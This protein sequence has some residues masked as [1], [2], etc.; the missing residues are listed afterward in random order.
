MDWRGLLLLGVFLTLT[1]YSSSQPDEN[2][3][4]FI[5]QMLNEHNKLRSEVKPTAANM[6]YMSWD[7]DLAILAK[8]WSDACIYAFNTDLL[9]PSTEYHPTFTTFEENEWYGPPGD[10]AKAIPEWTVGRKSFD[11][12]ANAC[13]VPQETC[14]TYTGMIWHNTYRV[15]CAATLCNRVKNKSG[16][17]NIMFIC[18]YAPAGNYPNKLPYTE[19][20]PCSKC[21]KDDTCE[22]NLC[23]NPK[24]DVILPDENAQKPETGAA[25]GS[26]AGR[27]EP[28]HVPPS[29]SEA[30]PNE[31]AE[32]RLSS[33]KDSHHLDHLLLCMSLLTCF[34]TLL[35]LL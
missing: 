10:Y 19:G 24:R 14:L 18:N 5:T 7:K 26:E 8:N 34:Y 27:D 28:A 11:Y 20:E 3:P 17:G 30:G 1:H 4:W 12:T 31:S 23:R 15:G 32:S 22:K 35:Y 13:S 21:D 9:K 25:A 29:G 16:R 6:L 33:K 2:D